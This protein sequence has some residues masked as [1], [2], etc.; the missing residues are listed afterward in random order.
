M[1]YLFLIS[2]NMTKTKQKSKI[3]FGN[4]AKNSLALAVLIGLVA[5]MGVPA[6]INAK[7]SDLIIKY[8]IIGQ[9]KAQFP[10]VEPSLRPARDIRSK[11]AKNGQKQPNMV[12][13]SVITAYTSTPDQTD[14]TP[15]IAA[16]G[17]HVY[18]GMIAANWLPFGTKV[19]IPD[20]YGDKVFTVED[21][22][23]ERYG[24]GRMDVW[25]DAPRQTAIQFGVR[26][27]NVEVY[28]PEYRLVRR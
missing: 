10:K 9:N 5:T 27:V 21:R 15:F 7:N 14:D 18:D 24:F 3:N 8:S 6:A 19:K 26:V 13:R 1:W 12:V 4:C 28:Y 23:N 17:A 16:N 2:L 11:V 20:I 22:M 25:M